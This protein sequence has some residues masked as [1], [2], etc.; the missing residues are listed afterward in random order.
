MAKQLFT[1]GMFRS[2]TTLLARLLD[3]HEDIVCAADPYRPFY[4][5]LRDAVAEDIGVETDPY[6]PL[7]DYFAEEAQVA[8][9]DAVQDATLDRPFERDRTELL[10]QLVDRAQGHAQFIAD[11]LTE[12]HVSGETFAD[13]HADLL[14]EVPE[15]YGTGEERWIGTKDTWATEFVPA[16]RRQYPDAKF[17]L[18]VRDPRAVCASK[19][20]WETMYPWLFL[21]RQ[22]RK[23][24]ML[25]HRY[26]ALAD[27]NDAHLV[28]YE[29]LVQ[30][31]ERTV[32]EI[33]DFL[34]VPVDEAV[35]N[36]A[37]FTDGRGKQWLQNTSHDGEEQKAEFNTDSV[38]KWRQTLDETVVEYV[39]RLCFGEMSLLGYEPVHADGLGYP[40][41]MVLSPPTE[42]FEDLA[43]WI[44][45]YYADR[46]DT[47][48][49]TQMSVETTRHRLLACSDDVRDSVADSVVRSHFI[50]E[51]LYD[52]CRAALPSQSDR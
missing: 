3:T 39:E 25:T 36:P 2:G 8:L 46:T 35:L 49:V 32:E 26:T 52:A 28:R 16:L 20:A 31:P 27:H 17:L 45:P 47:D 38:D 11:S 43:A 24:A 4:N 5:A 12:A 33:C 22:W 6:D 13:I 23:I 40:D 29:D 41:E 18:M 30:H 48:V 34:N 44:K 42:P 7:G 51:Q 19:Y 1:F 21:A 14:A 15:Q 10:S 37:N 50:D 9:F